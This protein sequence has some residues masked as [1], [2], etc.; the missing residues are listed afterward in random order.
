MKKKYG[1]KRERA[2]QKPMQR[3]STREK[4]L[5]RTRGDRGKRVKGLREKHGQRI[6]KSL[7]THSLKQS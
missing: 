2:T 6:N 1:Y 4:L 5:G 7:L 3:K